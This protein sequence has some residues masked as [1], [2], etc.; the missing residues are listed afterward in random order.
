MLEDTDTIGAYGNAD[1][2]R[3]GA[4]EVG[5]DR[6][7][8]VGDAVN[9][10]RRLCRAGPR[11]VRPGPE[12]HRERVLDIAEA[13]HSVVDEVIRAIEAE[14]LSDLASGKPDSVGKRAVESTDAV[15]GVALGCPP[16][17]QA[18]WRRRAGL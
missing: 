6:I 4:A 3:P 8:L 10:P 14:G 9:G 5:E 17:N 15:S 12:F 11:G 7:A 16:A 1:S 18:R 2:G 13:G